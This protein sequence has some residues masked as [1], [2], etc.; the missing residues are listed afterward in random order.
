MQYKNILISTMEDFRE[1]VNFSR[2]S[3]EEVTLLEKAGFELVEDGEIQEWGIPRELQK[4]REMQRYDLY[5]TYIWCGETELISV[6]EKTAIYDRW[7]RVDIDMEELQQY[8][9][10]ELSTE[11]GEEFQQKVAE[12]GEA[13]DRESQRQRALARRDPQAYQQEGLVAL[14]NL[15]GKDGDCIIC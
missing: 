6:S 2:L 5:N 13:A 7:C 8:I 4:I 15:A 14:A 9:D 11:T 1:T 3:S 10:G 12:A